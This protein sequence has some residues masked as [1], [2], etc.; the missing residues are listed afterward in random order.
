MR[1]FALAAGV[2]CILV[3]GFATAAVARENNGPAMVAQ[4]QQTMNRQAA[5]DFK[6][7]DAR[8]NVV[9]KKLTAAITDPKEKQLLVD[10]ELA[11]IKHRDLNAKMCAYPN[12]GGSIY[13]LIYFGAMTRVTKQRTAELEILLEDRNH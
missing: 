12:T 6:K 13:P 10:A 1:N 3:M 2:L 5:D 9:Y 4:D 7:A 8:L 11:W